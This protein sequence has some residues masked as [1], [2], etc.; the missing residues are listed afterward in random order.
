LSPCQLV[1]NPPHAEVL[2]RR[3]RHRRAEP[4]HGCSC[5]RGVLLLLRGGGHVNGDP[6]THGGPPRRAMVS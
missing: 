2:P 5:H 4:R 3:R 1:P 6:R